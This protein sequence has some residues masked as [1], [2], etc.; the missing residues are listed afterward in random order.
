[1]SPKLSVGGVH[2]AKK[3]QMGGSVEFDLQG[4]L[5][6]SRNLALLSDQLPWLQKRAIQTLRRRLYT[7]ARRD[8]QTEY[9][10][11]AR[12]VAKDLRT[13]VTGDAVTVTG[14]FRGIGMMQ[15]GARPVRKGVSYTFYR[16]R[17]RTLEKGAFVATLLSK[18][19]HVAQRHGD[20][21]TMEMGRYKGKLR[22]PIFTHYGPTVAQMLKSS[23]RPE[24]LADFAAGV[25]RS[26]LDRLFES[27]YGRSASAPLT[28][29]A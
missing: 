12:R 19:Q 3:P 27:R 1:M 24:R 17:G 18:N 28:P 16:G 22:Q 29:E 5:A 20:K 14:Y 8:I 9:N 13:K 15:F 11:G 23:G 25:L 4:A 21:R 26:E 2:P 7:Q 10:I 6:A